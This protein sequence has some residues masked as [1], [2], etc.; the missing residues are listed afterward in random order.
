[1]EIWC[2][3]Q[4]RV[5]ALNQKPAVS[6]RLWNVGGPFSTWVPIHCGVSDNKYIYLPF[7][8]S[9]MFSFSQLANNAYVKA[10]PQT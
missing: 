9:T 10:E 6:G 2:E 7:L 4:T 1:M 3:K 5:G 8:A